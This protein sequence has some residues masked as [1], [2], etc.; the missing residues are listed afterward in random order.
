MDWRIRSCSLAVPP[1][2]RVEHIHR[3]HRHRG[4]T[5]ADGV[6]HGVAHRGA[7]ADRGWLAESDNAA[8][9][10]FGPNVHVNYDVADIL[11]AGELVELHVG[12]EHA[13]AGVI[14][15]AFFEERRAD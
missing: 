8:L 3:S 6:G 10:V 12:V 1:F 7:D 15:D 11:D 4:N 14:E 9:I 2:E 5:L 13:A